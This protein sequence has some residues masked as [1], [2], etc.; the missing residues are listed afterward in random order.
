[1]TFDTTDKKLLVFMDFDDTMVVS[2]VNFWGNYASFLEWLYE[3]IKESKGDDPSSNTPTI[4]DTLT[5]LENF[6]AQ[7]L[8]TLGYS[9]ERMVKSFTSVL[10]TYEI[11]ITDSVN[12]KIKEFAIFPFDVPLI[13][14]EEVLSALARLK[15]VAR[16]VIWTRGKL[17]IQKRRIISC[18]LNE[19]IDQIYAF[20]EKSAERLK[21]SIVK[22]I[23]I[24]GQ[25]SVEAWMVG[26]SIQHDVL[27][28][29]DIGIQAILVGIEGTSGSIFRSF[30]T[31]D[32]LVAA[33][34]I[35]VEGSEDSE[36]ITMKEMFK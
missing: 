1:M 17:D 24:M 28:A 11:E 10:M 25:E 12:E 13:V 16:I 22:E 3:K 31:A 26:N 30:K 35:I 36:R 33:I 27:P 5:T 7:N 23:A 15:E 21:E 18:G 32:K 29:V 4:H 14:S 20:H 6:E 19:Y 8:L 9:P 34:N 2:A